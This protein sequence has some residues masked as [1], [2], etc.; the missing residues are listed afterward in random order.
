MADQFGNRSVARRDKLQER[1]A[2]SKHAIKCALLTLGWLD[3]L[4]LRRRLSALR[5]RLRKLRMT[6]A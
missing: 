2:G 6:G 3:R 1:I 4:R 5:L